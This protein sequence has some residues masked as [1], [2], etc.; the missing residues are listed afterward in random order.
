[1]LLTL[2][3]RAARARPRDCGSLGQRQAVLADLMIYRPRPAADSST[4]G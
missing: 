1:M 2:T 4:R 3:A